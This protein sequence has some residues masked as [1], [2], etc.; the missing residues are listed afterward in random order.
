[1]EGMDPQMI[2]ALQTRF[3]AQMQTRAMDVFMLTREELY[4]FASNGFILPINYF[5]EMTEELNPAVYDLMMERLVE[6]T[7]YS[8]EYDIL[9][10]DYMALS[11]SGVAFFEKFGIQTD[12]LYFALVI[13]AERFERVAKALEVILDA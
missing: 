9:T 5:I 8:R 4:E 12:D 3:F 6:I 7:F 11:L 2:M 1:M 13:N 10:T